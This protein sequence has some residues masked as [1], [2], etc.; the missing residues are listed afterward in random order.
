[1]KEKAKSRQ[2]AFICKNPHE[3]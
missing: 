1:M 3:S 2:K